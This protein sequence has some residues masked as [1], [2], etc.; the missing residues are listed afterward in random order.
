[1]SVLFIQMEKESEQRKKYILPQTMES[2]GPNRL[3]E[4]DAGVG[5]CGGCVYAWGDGSELYVCG[6]AGDADSVYSEYVSGCGDGQPWNFGS[7]VLGKR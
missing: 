6:F 2:N 4:P 7:T 1:M 3:A 5:G